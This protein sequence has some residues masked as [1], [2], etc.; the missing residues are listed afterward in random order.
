M[1]TWPLMKP[2]KLELN[3]AK[4]KRFW[5]IAG[6]D[7]VAV[8]CYAGPLYAG[9]V[10]LDYKSSYSDLVRD[11]KTLNDKQLEI[12]YK[13]VIH[14]AR[15]WSIAKAT[16]REIDTKGTSWAIDQ[17]MKRAVKGLNLKPNCLLIDFRNLS[18]IHCW[19]LA[20]IDGDKKYLCIAAASI[21]AKYHHD[22][23]ML[24]LHEKY[25]QYNWANNKGVFT[26]DHKERIIKYG[27]TPHHRKSWCKSFC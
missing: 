1:A 24:R 2:S 8:C 26:K 5:P 22:Q 10:I 9:A 17:A 14:K 15:A 16:V 20:E 18:G 6:V 13:E 4:D 21:V 25:P 23:E 19:Q 27:L 12:A 7:E 3:L 11:C